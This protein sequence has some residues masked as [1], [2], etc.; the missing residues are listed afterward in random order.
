MFW[1]RNKKKSVMHS[2]LG[3]CFDVDFAR[4][5]VVPVYDVVRTL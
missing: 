3:P 1:L 4:A 5:N 2:Y